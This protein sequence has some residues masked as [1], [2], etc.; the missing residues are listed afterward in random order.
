MDLVVR[1]VVGADQAELATD[2]LWAEGATAVEEQPG[3]VGEVVLV[4]GFPTPAAAA[5][6]ARS[7]GGQL[8]EVEESTWRD[9]WRRHAQPVWVGSLVVAPAWRSVEIGGAG[10][11]VSIDPGGCFGSGSHPTTRIMLGELQQRMAPGASVF[12][13]GTGSGV[14]AVAAARLGAARVVAVD[15]EAEAVEIT[16]ANAAGN[17][18]AGLVSA[19]TTDAAAVAGTFDV[20][21]ANLTAAVLAGLAGALVAAVASDGVLLLSGLLPGQWPHVADRFDALPVVDVVTLEGWVGV[22]LGSS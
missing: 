8:L 14:L 9:V 19:S 7:V 20:V 21:V 17:G 15:I 4:A 18:V 11:V 13:V 10:L 6:V 22:V 1:L 2:R 16:R 3:E 12:D 5:A